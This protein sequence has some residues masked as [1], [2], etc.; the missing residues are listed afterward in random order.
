M[1]EAMVCLDDVFE[2]CGIFAAQVIIEQLLNINTLI[3]KQ[4]K[5]ILK[6]GQL[7]T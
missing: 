4:N 5:N 1:A 2:M 7:Q 6:S 3:S